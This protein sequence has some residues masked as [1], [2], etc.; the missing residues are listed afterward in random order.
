MKHYLDNTI[1]INKGSDEA[2]KM[3]QQFREFMDLADDASLVPRTT[4]C[5]SSS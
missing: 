5:N 4:T 2:R 1:T 3:A